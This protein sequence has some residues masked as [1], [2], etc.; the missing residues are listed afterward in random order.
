MGPLVRRQLLGAAVDVIDGMAVVLAVEARIHRQVGVQPQLEGGERA[1]PRGAPDQRSRH[2]GFRRGLDPGFDGPVAD[3]VHH[4]FQPVDVFGREHAAEA[5]ELQRARHVGRLGAQHE[6]VVG[7]LGHV[8]RGVVVRIQIHRRP[9]RRHE[10]GVAFEHGGVLPIGHPVVQVEAVLRGLAAV[11]EVEDALGRAVLVGGAGEVG[12]RQQDAAGVLDLHAGAGVA[13][14][15]DGIEFADPAGA[16]GGLEDAAQGGGGQAGIRFRGHAL[17][18]HEQ[19]GLHRGGIAHGGQ[20]RPFVHRQAGGRIQAHGDVAVFRAE[21]VGNVW[22]GR[23]QSQFIVDPRLAVLLDLFGA[24]DHEAVR[25]RA[26]RLDPGLDRPRQARVG[27]VLGRNHELAAAA[28]PHRAGPVGRRRL[29]GIGSRRDFGGVLLAVVVRIGRIHPV[30]QPFRARQ[31]AGLLFLAVA[32][33]VAVGIGVEVVDGV[34]VRVGIVRIRPGQEF[35]EVR[36]AI[37]VRIAFGAVQARGR[38]RIEAHGLLPPIRHAVGIRVLEDR[39]EGVRREQGVV[40]HGGMEPRLAETVQRAVPIRRHGEV[41]GPGAAVV[42]PEVQ[43]GTAAHD[44]GQ[45]QAAAA[46]D[47]VGQGIQRIDGLQQHPLDAERI[48]HGVLA[49]QQRRRARH[50]RRGHRGA[51][52]A[53][54]LAARPG[55]ENARARRGQIHRCRAEAAEVRQLVA[56]VRRRDGHDVGNV[57]A[58]GIMGSQVVVRG[59]IARRG[60]EQVALRAGHL[61]GVVQR[62]AVGAAA[63]AVVAQ[64]RAVLPGVFQGQDGVGREAHAEVAQEADRHDLDF[65]VHAGHALVVVADGA[66]DARHVRAVAVVVHRVVGRQAQHGVVGAEVPA[67]DVVDVAVAVVV[68]I[69]VR[70]FAGIDPHVVGQVRMGVV[71]AG[72]DHRDDDVPAARRLVPGF[73][74]ADVGRRQ[75]G[76]LEPPLADEHRVVRRAVGTHHVIRL[77][78]EHVRIRAQFFQLGG[79]VVARRQLHPVD[80]HELERMRHVQAQ[81]RRDARDGRIGRAGLEAHQH[82][83]VGVLVLQRLGDR[84]LADFGIHR[85]IDRLERRGDLLGRLVLDLVLAGR[86]IQH[87]DVVHPAREGQFDE[88]GFLPAAADGQVAEH[89]LVGAEA[90]AAGREHV[91]AID[92]QLAVDEEAHRVGFGV[93]GTRDV[94]PLIRHDESGRLVAARGFVHAVGIVDAADQRFDRHVRRQAVARGRH[95]DVAHVGG[96]EARP[97]FAQAQFVVD[98]IAAVELQVGG[99]HRPADDDAVAGQGRGGLDPAHHGPGF[100]VVA[101]L[102]FHGQAAVAQEL[103]RPAHRRIE[104]PDRAGDA[105]GGALAD[106]FVVVGQAVVVRVLQ[107]E[108]GTGDVLLVPVRQA[109]AVEVLFAVVD[110]V[111]VGVGILRI[112]AQ[113]I[114]V[115]VAQAVAVGV[116]FAAVESGG[117]VRI[118]AVGDFP[119]VRQA[120]AV[121]VFSGQQHAFQHAEGTE[122]GPLRRVAPLRV[123]VLIHR[124][125]LAGGNQAPARPDARADR[126]AALVGDAFVPDPDVQIADRVGRLG[127]RHQ[128][129]TV[130]DLHG[131]VRRQQQD[132][133][134][135]V[136][137]LHGIVLRERAVFGHRRVDQGIGGIFHDEALAD[138]A[139]ADVVQQV[140]FVRADAVRLQAHRRQ[141]LDRRPPAQPGAAIVPIVFRLAVPP[142]EIAV[143]RR[144]GRHGA[145]AEHL[146]RSGAGILHAAVDRDDGSARQP[147]NAVHPVVHDRRRAHEIHAADDDGIRRGRPGRAVP[148]QHG[149]GGGVQDPHARRGFREV[150][151]RAREFGDAIG[152]AGPIAGSARRHQVAVARVRHRRRRRKIGGDHLAPDQHRRPAAVVQRIARH[153]A[154]RGQGRTVDVVVDVAFGARHGP[155]PNVVHEALEAFADAHERPRAFA[156]LQGPAQFRELL[157]AGQGAVDVEAQ[158]GDFIVVGRRQVD[159]AIRGIRIVGRGHGQAVAPVGGIAPHGNDLA[160]AGF[161]HVDVAHLGHQVGAGLDHA[162]IEVGRHHVVRGVLHRAA[163][164]RGPL[165]VGQGVQVRRQHLRF[166]RPVPQPEGVPVGRIQIRAGIAVQIQRHALRRTDGIDGR[167][168]VGFL[169]GVRLAVVVGVAQVGAATDGGFQPV[170]QAVAVE[171]FLAVHPAVFIRVRTVRIGLAPIFVLVVQP[172]AVRIPQRVDDPVDVGAAAVDHLLD[173]QA[174]VRHV[175]ALAVLDVGDLADFQRP[176]HVRFFRRLICIL[177]G[178]GNDAIGAR[179]DDDFGPVDDGHLRRV[180]FVPGDPRVHRRPVDESGPLDDDGAHLAPGRI[181]AGRNVVVVRRVGREG[182]QLVHDFPAVRQAVAV[183]VEFAADA[184]QRAAHGR[185]VVGV[186]LEGAADRVGVDGIILVVVEILVVEIPGDGQVVGEEIAE[187]AAL[188]APHQIFGRVAA[189]V[190]AE[191][192][193]QRIFLFIEHR[194]GVGHLHRVDQRG[195][196]VRD[197]L[198]RAR[199]APD[200]DFVEPQP[201]REAVQAVGG[202]FAE[203]QRTVVG[204][205]R[206]HGARAF[207]HHLQGLFDQ[208]VHV[209]RQ[210]ILVAAEHARQMDPLAQR[211]GARSRGPIDFPAQRFHLDV[212]HRIEAVDGFHAEIERPRLVAPFRHFDGSLNERAVER[213]GP[214]FR[215]DVDPR[216]DREVRRE[217]LPEGTAGHGHAV[218]A[219]DPGGA[220]RHRIVRLHGTGRLAA[221][222]DVHLDFQRVRPAVVV[223]VVA[224]HGVLQRRV[225]EDRRRG[226]VAGREVGD[227]R[228]GGRQDAVRIRQDDV[229]HHGGRTGG[230]RRE[231]AGGIDGLPE[232]VDSRRVAPVFGAHPFQIVEARHRGGER[233]EGAGAVGRQRGVHGHV[234]IAV[235]RVVV[236]IQFQHVVQIRERRHADHGGPVGHHHVDVGRRVGVVHLV[237]GHDGQQRIEE[238]G[239]D[240]RSVGRG[241]RRD[242]AARRLLAAGAVAHLARPKAKGTQ[243]AVVD[244][245]RDPGIR[246]VAGARH[247]IDAVAVLAEIFLVIYQ[248]IAIGIAQ[249]A[250][251]VVVAPR[252]QAMLPFPSVGH[253]V[254][255]AVGVVWLGPAFGRRHFGPND[256]SVGQ[257]AYEVLLG[258]FARIR[259]HRTAPDHGLRR[260]TRLAQ[261]EAGQRLGTIKI[262]LVQ[263]VR[264]VEPVHAVQAPLGIPHADAADDG[265]GN[266]K[267]VVRRFFRRRSGHRG[268]VVAQQ[269]MHALFPEIGVAVAVQIRVFGK[270]GVVLLRH[271][272]VEFVVAGVFPLERIDQPVVVRIVIQRRGPHAAIDRHGQFVAHQIR[273]RKIIVRSAIDDDGIA[274]QFLDGVQAVAIGIHPRIFACRLGAGRRQ[275]VRVVPGPARIRGRQTR[276]DFDGIPDRVSIGVRRLRIGPGIALLVEIGNAVAIRVG[277]FRIRPAIDPVGRGADGPIPR[278]PDEPAIDGRAPAVEFLQIGQAVFVGVL[279]RTVARFEIDLAGDGVQLAPGVQDGELVVVGRQAGPAIRAERRLRRRRKHRRRQ[280]RQSQET[281]GCPR[282][283]LRRFL[284]GRPSCCLHLRLHSLT[285]VVHS[286]KR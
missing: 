138:H 102:R 91:V 165:P 279:A 230:S 48:Q 36:Q 240:R 34:V 66:D 79:E 54:V 198:G 215:L 52:E 158:L 105:L 166:H 213:V 150:P 40:A 214:G 103:H 136:Q 284:H 181:V 83:A 21:G 88:V 195:P 76:V 252:I 196:V 22:N 260:R 278:E 94:R 282:V 90:H 228:D 148:L 69:V 121:G 212:G 280:Q 93:V 81:G 156:A 68:E 99:L 201:V 247:P 30:A 63:P 162:Q 182:I 274:R 226:I 218:V 132:A 227:R 160:G 144:A 167:R 98:E 111:V 246:L 100:Q 266:F 49:Q 234:E 155:Q 27:G 45:V 106:R 133:V 147:A 113:Q 10:G 60:H 114:F 200:A 1:V 110:A 87:L 190:E 70:Y 224:R 153:Q 126:A 157:A 220:R 231:H 119:V 241:I 286:K 65:P 44:L 251:H 206:G 208:A 185:G 33:A 154:G 145:F 174:F 173:R 164:D 109:V 71:H 188:R 268:P 177:K 131:L 67:A 271:D 202:G 86:A 28:E 254:V 161:V 55:A 127:Q 50:E 225:V 16:D 84:E 192:A 19:A 75:G 163:D 120:V 116:A 124:G 9:G 210:R 285:V 168:A 5:A 104:R 12:F 184:V 204:M 53:D 123:P 56:H 207:F 270:G 62:L 180:C 129:R 17:A 74:R 229:A 199:H 85:Q 194:G 8:R 139:G 125:I 273:G 244:G 275:S 141:P 112:V 237:R 281:S 151:G 172:V 143:G 130:P 223:R 13:P 31:G 25:A 128:G 57:V 263:I 117:I 236:R 219:H 256:R 209:E 238:S 187:E 89:L 26:H 4:R 20:M 24:A 242:V 134:V 265:A 96:E 216:L 250:R 82:E 58:A 222:P 61:D 140:G 258:A 23:G 92:R 118:E 142:G 255:V 175:P 122:A 38:Q 80:R 59:R 232:G 264:H 108:A 137:R 205:G 272:R 235:E 267:S 18:V 14:D 77:G 146:R 183:R 72:V 42:E 186:E 262:G 41:F 257:H 32:Q 73:D 217:I 277:I 211:Q 29:Q 115:V 152:L 239:V 253:A 171:V 249:N 243:H 159:Q 47:L 7:A 97:H 107:I 283:P 35:I 37:A 197:F 221:F 39:H 95:A 191:I 269:R 149:A 193:Q 170:G 178:V 135:H 176:R 15:A 43:D 2:R 259:T 101:R 64:A 179:R 11:V 46:D 276:E 51:V 78:I 233:L 261:I 169:H 189:V 203:D 245:T 3:G 248:R 6:G